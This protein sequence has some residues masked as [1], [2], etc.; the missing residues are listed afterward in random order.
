VLQIGAVLKIPEAGLEMQSEQTKARGDRLPAQLSEAIF[1]AELLTE[2][3]IVRNFRPGDQIQPL[4][5]GGHKKVKDLFIDAKVPLS[6]RAT[7]PLLVAKK[8]VLWIPKYA[9]SEIA[10]VSEKTTSILRIKVV[11]IGG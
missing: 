1:D 7:W 5:M 2:R 6:I 10:R 4:N 11:S 9:R 3:L 8:N